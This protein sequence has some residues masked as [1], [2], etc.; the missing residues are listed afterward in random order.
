MQYV[1]IDLMKVYKGLYYLFDPT[2]HRMHR[3]STDYLKKGLSLVA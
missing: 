2:I 3:Y 1:L